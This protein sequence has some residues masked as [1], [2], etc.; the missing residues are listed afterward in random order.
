M[1][2]TECRLSVELFRPIFQEIKDSETLVSLSLT[3]K[4]FQ[5][6][7]QRILFFFPAYFS[8]RPRQHLRLLTCLLNNPRLAL[9]VKKYH[10]PA[11]IGPKKAAIWTLLGSVLPYMT[12]LKEFSVSAFRDDINLLPME[13]LAFQL[14]VLTWIQVDSMNC[15]IF[16][17]WLATQK[18]LKKLKWISRTPVEVPASAC[19]N[20]ISLE[21]T[22]H[23]INALLPGR[24]IKRLYWLADPALERSPLVGNTLD[25][26]SGSMESLESLS[27]DTRV[28]AI[29]YHGLASHLP[30]LVLLELNGCDVESIN[31]TVS[32]ISNLRHIVLSTQ[33]GY[34]RRDVFTMKKRA[35]VVQG[36]FSR[37]PTLVRVDIAVNLEGSHCKVFYE[38][39][40]NG[41]RREDLVPSTDIFQH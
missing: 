13:K 29:H 5:S 22:F 31:N 19:P 25:R 3:N 32:S 9:L 40:E 20:L 34:G 21:G 39:W 27:F 12:N 2:V 26:L 6:E 23:A 10:V 18:K 41:N 17:K 15:G 11:V 37:S 33:K 38:R 14:E 24:D 7:A 16:P 30:S 36:V 8:T 28:N 35:D 4:L 1:A